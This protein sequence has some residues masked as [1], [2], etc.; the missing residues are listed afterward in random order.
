MFICFLHT[1]ETVKPRAQKQRFRKICVHSQRRSVKTVE[2][3]KRG[4]NLLKKRKNPEK[5][6]KTRKKKK[7]KKVGK[8]LKSLFTKGEEA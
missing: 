8:S 6:V 5:I 2:R 1:Q 7:E 4:K 3:E